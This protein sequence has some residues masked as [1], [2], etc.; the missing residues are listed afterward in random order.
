MKKHVDTNRIPDIRGRGRPKFPFQERIIQDLA[1]L[2]FSNL[3]YKSIDG[4]SNAE[5]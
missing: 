1:N 2:G 3:A 4:F 5:G